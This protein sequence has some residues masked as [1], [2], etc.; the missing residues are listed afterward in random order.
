M[1]SLLSLWQSI[2]ADAA[3]QCRTSTIRDQQ[4]IAERFEHEGQELFTLTLPEVGKEF[5][6]SLDLGRVTDDLLSLTGAKTRFPLFLRNLFL[7]VFDR[8]GVRLLDDPSI[9]AIQAI[10]QLT[11]AFGKVNL[12]CSDARVVKAFESFIECEQSLRDAIYVPSSEQYRDL[13][14]ISSMLFGD[15]FSAIDREVYEGKIKP[16]HG[17]GATADKLMGNHK[18]R[19]GEW[20]L[21]LESIFSAFENLIPSYRYIHSLDEL[22]WLDP[23]AERP[24]RVITVPKTMK[25]PRIIAIEPTCMQYMQQGLMEKFVDYLESDSLVQ[26][27]IGFTDQTPNQ[28]LACEGSLSGN[29]ATLDLSEAS[30]RVSIRLVQQIF[31]NYGHLSE[32]ILATRSRRADVPGFGILPLAKFASMGSALT[33]PIEECVFLSAIFFGIES[34][35]NRRLTRKDISSFRGKVRVYG[36]DIVV[37]IEFVLPVV[38]ALELFGFKVNHNKSFWTGRYRESCGREYFDGHDVSIFRVRQLLPLH[39]ADVP[40]LISTVSLRNLAY[41][42]GYW[43]TARYLDSILKGLIPFPN[44]AETSAVLG[45]HS[46]LGYSEDF[47]DPVLQRPLVKGA[48]VRTRIPLSLVEDEFALLKCFLKR[49]SNP[50][51]DERHLER[52]GRPDTV[53]IKIRKACPY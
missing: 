16:K 24:V 19:Q 21:R 48:V 5:E 10:R 47:Y 15:V 36:D 32:A 42:Q 45:R 18:Y 34:K 51:A 23:D 7:L 41:K 27:M 35:L 31:M 8:S 12:P 39:R 43:G 33:F 53:G 3:V 2:A 4:K 25:T 9:D 37:P 49:G 22:E 1:K 50:Y 28:R 52:Q 26:D 13:E 46:V 38:D 20:T 6:R 17:P 40:A 44:V 14:R 11:L 29:L 30:D